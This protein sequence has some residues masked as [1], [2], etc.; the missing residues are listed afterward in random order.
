MID[1]LFG[2]LTTSMAFLLWLH[3][4]GPKQTV[5]DAEKVEKSL[6]G[7]AQIIVDQGQRVIAKV[8]QK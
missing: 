4:R 1:F 5:S 7:L 6:E 8:E 2:C 3:F